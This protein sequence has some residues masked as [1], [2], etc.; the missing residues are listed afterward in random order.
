MHESSISDRVRELRRRRGMTQE[1]LAERA[2]LSLA[3]IKKLEQGGTCRMETYH[4]LARTLDVT[5]VWFASAGSPEPAEATVDEVVLADIR[6]AINPPVG[7]AGRPLYGTADDDHPDLKR[8]GRAVRMVAQ[9]YHADEYDDLAKMMPALVRSAHHHVDAYDAGDARREALRLRADVTGLAGRYLIQIRAHDLALI[10]LHASLRD[11]LEIEDLP[12]AAASV[13]SQAW[14][15][16]RQGRFDEVERLSITTADQIEPKMSTATPDELSG[17]G[18]L[19]LRAAAAASRNNRAAE[20]RDYT[21]TA[22]TAGTRLGEQKHNLSGH[23]TF[24]PLDPQIVLAEV[25]M[26]DDRPDKVIQLA[27]ELPRGVG[28]TDTSSW[29]RHRLDIARARLR[30]GDADKAT[31]IMTGLRQTHPEWLRYQ[32]YGRD[33]TREIIEARPRMPSR[34]MLDLADFMGV[35]P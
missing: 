11:A 22:A 34:A 15:M 32:Q 4:Q 18:W 3:V 35:E 26:L 9:K 25:E 24:G 6:S 12:L 1:E 10:A 17:W 33:I 2:G 20:A 28:R 31:N 27:D 7:M 23:K 5:T 16:L 14:A 30:L 13:S 8:L 21:R 29:D 19:L